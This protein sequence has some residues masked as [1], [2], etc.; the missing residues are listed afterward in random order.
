MFIELK[1]PKIHRP[2]VNPL[3]GREK[4]IVKVSMGLVLVI[5]L[6][7]ALMTDQG[8]LMRL[9]RHID[10]V[11]ERDRIASTMAP[12]VRAGKPDAVIWYALNYP[13]APLDPLR[14]LAY[15]GNPKAQW[16]LAGL[17]ATSNPSEA[18]R[19][20]MMAADAGYPDAV[21]YE[22]RTRAAAQDGQS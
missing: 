1:A 16:T 21:N 4:K 15:A 12:F 5:L 19:L 18:M 8:P 20:A 3:N 6:L 22:I 9:A 17:L 11:H 14:E 2:Q 10:A 13:A 7:S